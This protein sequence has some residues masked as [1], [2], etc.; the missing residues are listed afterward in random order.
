[1][2]P[3][4][5]KVLVERARH[6]AGAP[7]FNAR[8]E[9]RRLRALDQLDEAPGR[10]SMPR[11]AA[12]TKAA[13]AAKSLNENLAPLRRLLE[14]RVGRR[15]DTVYAEVRAGVDPDNAV[16]AH[17]L[18]HLWQFVHR[19][20]EIEDGT[21]FVRSW[22]RRRALRPPE[23]FVD[24]RSGLLRA[25]SRRRKAPPPP[26]KTVDLGDGTHAV[27]NAHGWWR[28]RLEPIPWD[29]PVRDVWLKR[30]I[31]RRSVR[32]GRRGSREVGAGPALAAYGRLVY[33]TEKRQ[34]GTRE[35]RRLGLDGRPPR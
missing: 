5:H 6:G 16:R 11:T 22:G 28:V 13:S 24:P 34:L 8:G 33:A 15:W 20:V 7:R 3:D 10:V 12:A 18:Q 4:M 14:R 29:A 21:I 9:T 27:R 35:I 23:L 26:D 30:P 25:A 19:D 32:D 17:I 31:H 1:M 2:R